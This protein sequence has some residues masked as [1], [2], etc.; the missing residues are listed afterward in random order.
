MNQQ[1]K[2]IDEVVQRLSSQYGIPKVRVKD[3]YTIKLNEL[4]DTGIRCKDAKLVAYVQIEEAY[5]ST[6]IAR[7]N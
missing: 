2:H 7:S 3:E 4:V 1:Q 5:K 6:V